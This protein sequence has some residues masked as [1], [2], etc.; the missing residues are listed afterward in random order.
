MIA[1]LQ[2]EVSQLKA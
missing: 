2:K 1:F